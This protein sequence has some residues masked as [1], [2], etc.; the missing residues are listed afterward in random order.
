MK[1]PNKEDLPTA[2]CKCYNLSIHE[3]ARYTNQQEIT[4]SELEP[5]PHD[6]IFK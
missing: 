4:S 6:N 1:F 5:Y 2:D 3:V